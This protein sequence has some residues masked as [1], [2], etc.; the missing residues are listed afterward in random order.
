MWFT[1]PGFLILGATRLTDPVG[2]AKHIA[3]VPCQ[4]SCTGFGP[5]KAKWEFLRH[6]RSLQTNFCTGPDDILIT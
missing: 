6:F 3:G 4:I 1:Q 5:L 2:I